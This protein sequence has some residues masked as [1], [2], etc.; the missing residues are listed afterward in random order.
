MVA[1][2]PQQFIKAFARFDEDNP[3]KG[4]PEK[5]KKLRTEADRMITKLTK[6]LSE[7]EASG[8]E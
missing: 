5:L 2:D 8:D 1:K 6:K 7:L 3:I 4:T